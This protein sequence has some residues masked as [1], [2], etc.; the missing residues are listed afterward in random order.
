MPSSPSRSNPLK[1]NLNLDDIH[2]EAVGRRPM[3]RAVQPSLEGPGTGELGSSFS[4]FTPSSHPIP[5]KATN[6]PT[7]PAP[8]SK[9][10][11]APLPPCPLAPLLP[12]RVKSY[13]MIAREDVGV[14]ILEVVS[15]PFRVKSY[16]M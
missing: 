11:P 10:T 8:T 15:I 16:L 6:P 5:P 9:S 2:F 13:L 12:F 3:I 1:P 4:L 7:H 14:E